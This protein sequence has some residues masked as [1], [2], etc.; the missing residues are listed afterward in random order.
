MQS[1]SH[2]MLFERHLRDRLRM[3]FLY[4]SP[5]LLQLPRRDDIMRIAAGLDAL[6]YWSALKFPGNGTAGRAPQRISYT[7]SSHA[8]RLASNARLDDI[9]S[10]M[11]RRRSRA[12]IGHCAFHAALPPSKQADYRFR[13][14]YGIRWPGVGNEK[15]GAAAHTILPRG[16]P[17]DAAALRF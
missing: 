12:Y 4:C 7:Y 13:Q 17:L 2:M 3:R 9:A 8:S 16:L 10:Q 15:L 11:H 5:L 1:V 6:S 14:D